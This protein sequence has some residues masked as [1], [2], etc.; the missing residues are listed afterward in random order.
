MT[1]YQIAPQWSE[2]RDAKEL[3]P[4]A[5]GY[6]QAR[7]KNRLHEL[8]LMEFMKLEKKE[9]LTKADIARRIRKRPEQVTRLLGGPGNWT[10]DTVSDLLLAMGYELTAQVKEFDEK[11]PS[12]TSVE[13]KMG[14]HQQRVTKSNV[15]VFPGTTG[16]PI[17][18]LIAASR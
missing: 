4:K 13:W 2:I 11:A 14:S 12:I 15:T 18:S 7:L 5:L 9:G 6:F 1:T 17:V 8:V 10:L 3:S 16:M